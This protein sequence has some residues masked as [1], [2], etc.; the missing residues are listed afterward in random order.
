MGYLEAGWM[1]YW[2]DVY[3]GGF[4]HGVHEAIGVVEAVMMAGVGRAAFADP[5]PVTLN[6]V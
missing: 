1:D 2:L 3:E 5:A 4:T 6:R